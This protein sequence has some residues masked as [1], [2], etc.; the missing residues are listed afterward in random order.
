MPIKKEKFKGQNE[1]RKLLE[2]WNK[3]VDD[4]KKKKQADKIMYRIFEIKGGNIR[5]F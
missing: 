2:K 3:I 5:P 4:P 1:V